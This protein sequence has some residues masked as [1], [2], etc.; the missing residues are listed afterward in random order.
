MQALVYSLAL[1]L[2]AAAGDSPT[3]ASGDPKV[4]EADDRM[5]CRKIRNTGTRFDTR[6]CKRASEWR[7]IEENSTA[8]VR[9]IQGRPKINC[10]QPSGAAC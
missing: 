8:A 3:V 6:I 7:A 5:V 10:T 1:V 2:S 4:S 9:E